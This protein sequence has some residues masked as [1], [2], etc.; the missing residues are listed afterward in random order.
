MSTAIA[1]RGARMLMTIS[2]DESAAPRVRAI[3]PTT[4]A[5][6]GNEPSPPDEGTGTTGSE[7]TIRTG[8]YV[9]SVS[10]NSSV[11]VYE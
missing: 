9:H 8:G 11:T 1:T 5:Y 10:V 6:T 4:G 3:P 7:P 2:E